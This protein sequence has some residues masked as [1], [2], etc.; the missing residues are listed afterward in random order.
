MDLTSLVELRLDNNTIKKIEN[1]GHL[2][3]LTWLGVCSG[4][5]DCSLQR[6]TLYAPRSIVQQH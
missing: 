2:V 1:I 5:S 6:L 4:H 3:N